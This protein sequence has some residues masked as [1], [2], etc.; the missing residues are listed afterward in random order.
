M[1]KTA[2]R[3]HRGCGGHALKTRMYAPVPV[4][5]VHMQI[6]IVAGI[7]LNER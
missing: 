1:T 6:T 3:I 7:L 4:T 5:V 2:M